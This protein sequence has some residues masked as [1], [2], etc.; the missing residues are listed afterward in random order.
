M[1]KIFATLFFCFAVTNVYVY[2]QAE[3]IG[4]LLQGIMGV[5]GSATQK[6]DC[7]TDGAKR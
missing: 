1:Y 5:A 7:R 4:S 3:I 6:T 2:A